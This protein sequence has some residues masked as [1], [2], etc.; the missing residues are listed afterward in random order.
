MKHVST[1]KWVKKP[2][3]LKNILKKLKKYSDQSN[4]N[5]GMVLELKNVIVIVMMNPSTKEK[6][7]LWANNNNWSLPH[8]LDKERFWGF[9]IEAYRN[10]DD[11]IPED[12]F[13]AF[14]S[15]FYN[16]EDTLTNYYIK[17]EDGIDLLHSYDKK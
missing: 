9:V 3:N 17:Y 10:G 14:L 1:Q 5:K 11:E 7:E 8:P 15:N 12:E 16:D 4:H 13:Y 2:K 6:L